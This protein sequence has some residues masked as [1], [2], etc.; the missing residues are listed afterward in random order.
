MSFPLT[1]WSAPLLPRTILSLCGLLSAPTLL[2]SLCHEA[3]RLGQ[4]ATRLAET[5]NARPSQITAAATGHTIE[6]EQRR[7]PPNA[8]F[9]F[10][11]SSS[12]VHR[13]VTHIEPECVCRNYN[14]LDSSLAYLRLV[15]WWVGGRAAYTCFAA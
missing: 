6:K 14:S 7:Q 11:G 15:G 2:P 12:L 8:Q 13:R 3:R 10:A 4:P 9:F 1:G 5:S